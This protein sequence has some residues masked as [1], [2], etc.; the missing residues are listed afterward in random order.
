MEEIELNKQIKIEVLTLALGFV[1]QV[2]VEATLFHET[3]EAN[4]PMAGMLG[5]LDG[6]HGW[7]D[8][9]S[10]AMVQATE[11]WEFNQAVS[12]SNA[13]IS[14]S[15]VVSQTHV[16]VVFAWKPVAGDVVS[17]DIP[18]DATAICWVNTSGLLCA[19]SNQIAVEV[20]GMAVDTS[21]WSRVLVQS[22]YVAK[23]WSLWL[24]G[25]QAIDGF[26]FY[27]TDASQLAGITFSNPTTSPGYVD[28]IQVSANFSTPQPGDTDGDG[29]ADDWEVL[30]FRSPNISSGG[31]ADQDSDASPDVDEEIAGTNPTNSGSFF[32][33][34]EGVL[35]DASEYVIRWPSVSGRLYAVDFC[36]NLVS[37]SWSNLVSDLPA[38]PP[39]NSH[40][41]LVGSAEAHFIRVR[42]K[43]Q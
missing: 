8:P 41:G 10:N 31:A 27:G 38:T 9:S 20:S 39:E 40:T 11:S 37:G 3:F 24:D 17:G 32:N 15:L 22:D 30:Y 5:V 33:I 19:Y 42:V 25:V 28:D 21:Q 26:P 43:K 4:T 6:Q 18:S 35:L 29:L 14:Q 1:W 2:G 16:Q 7:S 13:T 36:T 23:E 34:T 12:I